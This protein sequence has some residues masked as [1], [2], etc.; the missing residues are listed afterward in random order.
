MS[1][2]ALVNERQMT[3][4]DAPV[5]AELLR[6]SDLAVL[7]HWDFTM[8]ELEA[9]LS[10]DELQHLGWYDDSGTL[11]AYGWAGDGGQSSKIHLDVYVHPDVSEPSVGV[12]VLAALEERGR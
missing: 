10:N 4:A 8:T 1:R 9:D 3:I 6:A 2:S 11:V 7:G 5:I 12:H